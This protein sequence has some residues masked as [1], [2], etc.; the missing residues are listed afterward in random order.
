MSA[1]L[2]EISLYLYELNI[3][4]VKFEDLGEHHFQLPTSKYNKN[5]NFSLSM[6]VKIEEEGEYIKIYAPMAFIV[7]YTKSFQFLSACGVIE[8]NTKLVQFEYDN[9]TGE[10]RPIVE[11]PL[12][13]SKVTREQLKRCIFGLKAEVER[14]FYVLENIIKTGEIDF[15][16]KDKE[17]PLAHIAEWLEL[18]PEELLQNALQNKRN[19]L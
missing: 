8:Y 15:S 4:F 3:R 13:D 16:L 11:F 2:N 19:K 7:P 9:Q 10:V 17:T 14:F 12:M 6:V 5:G 18:I 1:T